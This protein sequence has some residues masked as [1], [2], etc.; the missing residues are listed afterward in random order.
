VLS[1][2]AAGLRA[3][4]ADRFLSLVLD[5]VLLRSRGS[6][7]RARSGTSPTAAGLQ[8]SRTITSMARSAARRCTAAPHR[9]CG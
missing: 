3:G 8:F 9:R 4:D 5:A 6:T 2:S 7:A 1:C